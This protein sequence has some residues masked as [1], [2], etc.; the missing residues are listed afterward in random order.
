MEGMPCKAS[1][2]WKGYLG[3]RSPRKRNPGKSDFGH[4]DPR[5]TGF[6]PGSGNTGP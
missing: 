6:D 3:H 2:D 1:G 5:G 4:L